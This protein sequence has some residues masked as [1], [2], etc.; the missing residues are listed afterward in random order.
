MAT[1][2]LLLR[3]QIAE[4]LAE[5]APDTGPR[6]REGDPGQYDAE[7]MHGNFT[8][9]SGVH[10]WCADALATMI[11]TPDAALEEWNDDIQ[12][13]VRYLLSCEVGR[14][15]QAARAESAARAAKQSNG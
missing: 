7:P 13:A 4:I 12:A 11:S 9:E 3:D 2:N 10:L 8:E 1:P 5:E 14:A 6:K 15:R